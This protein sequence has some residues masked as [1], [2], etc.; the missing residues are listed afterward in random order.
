MASDRFPTFHL[1]HGGGPWPY[2]DEEARRPYARLE[3]SLRELQRLPQWERASAAREAHPR[4]E[5]LLPLHIAVGAAEEEPGAVTDR[6]VDL[7]G[8]ITLSSYRFG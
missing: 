4:E 8:S 2:M 5:H 3:K 1:S 6:E 7:L